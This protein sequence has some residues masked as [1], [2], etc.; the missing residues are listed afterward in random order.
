MIAAV[1]A[2]S[3]LDYVPWTLNPIAYI[4]KHDPYKVRNIMDML[5]SIVNGNLL[6]TPCD[7]L[8]GLPQAVASLHLGD[9]LGDHLVAPFLGFVL[10]TT[11]TLY[12]GL[13]N[14]QQES[15]PPCSAFSYFGLLNKQQESWPP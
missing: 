8:D 14:E 6:R 10:G 15:W 1:I 11:P 5:R 7:V 13:L 12:F 3:P 9:H 4:I 2:E